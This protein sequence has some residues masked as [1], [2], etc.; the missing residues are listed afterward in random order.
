MIIGANSLIQSA[1]PEILNTPESFHENTMD[2]LQENAR[3]CSE[4]LK[5]IPGLRVVE[6]QGAMYL[7]VSMN[8]NLAGD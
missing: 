4:M 5:E 6:P 7:M 1:I 2:I 3:L 8:I